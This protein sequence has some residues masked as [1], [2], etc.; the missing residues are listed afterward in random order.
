MLMRK[1]LFL[2]CALCAVALQAQEEART[3]PTVIEVVPSASERFDVSQ[4]EMTLDRVGMPD[5]G[6]TWDAATLTFRG[7][8]TY[9]YERENYLSIKMPDGS[10][11][12]EG[13]LGVVAYDNPYITS[14]NLKADFSPYHYVS[15]VSAS[16]SEYEV[17]LQDLSL[18]SG[19]AIGVGPLSV[20]AAMMPDGMYK[21]A[22]E[23]VY[24]V[25]GETTD[26][27]AV[28]F[29]GGT[30]TVDD[31]DVAVT[32][33]KPLAEMSLTTFTIEDAEGRPAEGAD[34]YL[35]PTD[36]DFYTDA[37]GKLQVYLNPGSY[38]YSLY[39][40]DDYINMWD[41]E[42]AFAFVA[43][44]KETNVNFS[45]KDN[46]WKKVVFSAEMENPSS[47]RLELNCIG[48]EYD[49]YY[50]N[51]DQP[52]FEVYMPEGEFKYCFTVDGYDF[53]WL[54]VEG[55]VNTAETQE[56]KLSFDRADYA[57][58][59]F[60][61]VNV[62]DD[63]GSLSVVI[64]RD[65]EEV[66]DCGVAYPGAPEILDGGI[67]VDDGGGT[68]SVE[69]LECGTHL[70]PG[71]YVYV[72]KS[73]ESWNGRYNFWAI[74]TLVVG[75]DDRR[76]TVDFSRLSVT[77]VAL[78]PRDVP[79]FLSNHHLYCDVRYGQV[80]SLRDIDVT[81]NYSGNPLVVRLPEGDYAFDWEAEVY[82]SSD[83]PVAFAY[84]EELEVS[85]ASMTVG[86]DFA[87]MGVARIRASAIEGQTVDYLT[88]LQ[89]GRQFASGDFSSGGETYLVALP[90]TY[91]LKAMASDYEG[92]NI[93]LSPE[94]DVTLVAGQTVNVGLAADQALEGIMFEIDV[95][96]MAGREIGYAKVTVDGEVYET[97]AYGYVTV[98]NI[99]GDEVTLRVEAPGYLPYEKVF[100]LNK[101]LELAGGAYMV[102]VL[103]TG[104]SPSGIESVEDGALT[105]ERT[106][107]D[108][109]IVIRN[110]TGKTW[111]VSL[112]GLG[113]EVLE[114]VEAGQ[115]TTVVPADGLRKGLYLL[116]MNDG[117]SHKTVKV[118][119]K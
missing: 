21:R 25:T 44:G 7:E 66:A 52:Y 55:I 3:L 29:D 38:I 45:Y 69:P 87:E 88:V 95:E 115:G 68:R 22:D 102:V 26:G 84:R 2:L 60:E 99:Q 81:G 9:S 109:Q 19:D 110:E 36:A 100:R 70:L 86:P 89:D 103:R 50:G 114:R 54:P 39:I 32:V 63:A 46:G 40:G 79:E 12:F 71:T 106:M 41:V 65:N 1:V 17:T 18:N 104:G 80:L 42:E 67:A 58:V 20:H 49:E 75:E 10:I 101:V 117:V 77:E 16:P 116:T 59:D 90:G 33:G 34:I 37:D 118:V 8:V 13:P 96:N 43:S 4:L 93:H 30:V 35:H 94:K 78:E 57:A 47:A 107:V 111:N 48:V 28:A 105:V 23:Y 14:V 56:V 108:R 62:P 97:D 83:V 92:F 31:R 85:G 73:D 15:F 27:I 76:I 5:N 113:G 112:V 24:T 98:F 82:G 64:F 61:M 51:A 6:F 53:S 91:T 119:K 74:D 11:S 72:L